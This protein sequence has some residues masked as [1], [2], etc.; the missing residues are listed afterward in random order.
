MFVSYCNVGNA[1]AILPEVLRQ[2]V[3]Q[4][5][6]IICNARVLAVYRSRERA[7]GL[8]KNMLDLKSRIVNANGW[9]KSEGVKKLVCYL[10]SIYNT[11]DQDT[12]DA[13]AL[14]FVDT[15][16]RY[17]GELAGGDDD[18]AEQEAIDFVNKCLV[19]EE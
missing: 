8:W 16:E 19:D 18:E 4:V 9:W 6:P 2:P 17:A 12:K 10:A 1:T 3:P 14:Y 13:I 7:T 5:V 15:S 11:S